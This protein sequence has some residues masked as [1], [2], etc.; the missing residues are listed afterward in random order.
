M[1]GVG[2][3]R[4]QYILSLLE[5]KHHVST[6]DECKWYLKIKTIFFFCIRKCFHNCW[7]LPLS[8]LSLQNNNKEFGGRYLRNRPPWWLSSKESS[9]QCIRRGFHPWV[10]KI[11][12]R[13]KWQPSPVFLPGKSMDGGAWWAMVHGVAKSQ[14]QLSNFIF[15]FSFPPLTNTNHISFLVRFD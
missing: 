2:I 4:A 7:E 15:F 8:S 1:L 9:C 3:D 14:T 10:R 11:P 13:R 12:C 5:N 6:A